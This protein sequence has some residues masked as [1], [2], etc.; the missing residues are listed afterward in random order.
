MEFAVGFYDALGAGKEIEDAFRVAKNAIALEGIHGACT[1]V[2]IQ[3][4]K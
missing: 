4:D 3:Q 2:L 1:A